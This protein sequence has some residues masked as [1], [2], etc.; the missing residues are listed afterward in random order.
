V[1]PSVFSGRPV[2]DALGIRYYVLRD[3]NA[4]MRTINRRDRSLFKQ[5]RPPLNAGHGLIREFH[6]QAGHMEEVRP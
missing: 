2:L 4:V 3:R 1:S 5:S 6:P